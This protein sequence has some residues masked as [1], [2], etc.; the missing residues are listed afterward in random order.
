MATI[1]SI[2]IV[3]ESSVLG[4][5]VSPRSM[6]LRKRRYCYRKFWVF[7]YHRRVWGLEKY[8]DKK[9]VMITMRAGGA[10]AVQTKREIMPDC[11]VNL[12]RKWYPN[13][14]NIAYM[15]HRWN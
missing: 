13:P 14:P 7:L 15:G 11:I 4:V 6:G 9:A 12:V 1:L 3:T 8:Q 5:P 2:G 10:A